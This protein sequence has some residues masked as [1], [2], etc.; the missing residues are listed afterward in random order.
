MSTPELPLLSIVIVAYRSAGEIPGCIASLPRNLLGRWVETVV[1]DNSPD[2]GAG[3]F[4]RDEYPWIDYVPS[5]VNLGFG[6]ASNLGYRRTRGEYVLFLNPDT[7]AN[8]GALVH[9]LRRLQADPGIG[10]ISPRLVQEDGTMDLA[11]RRSIPTL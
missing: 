2:D 10:L 9:C 4:L 6:R 3:D 11:C 7:I 1:V 5:A 8:E